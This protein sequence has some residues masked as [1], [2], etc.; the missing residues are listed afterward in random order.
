MPSPTALDLAL[1]QVDLC[2]VSVKKGLTV[3]EKSLVSS[4]EVGLADGSVSE[5]GR[6]EKPNKSLEVAKWEEGLV[7]LLLVLLTAIDDL[8]PICMVC[9][10]LRIFEVGYK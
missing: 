6:D 5:E 9:I 2:F 3:G 10:S 7:L 8:F 1:R 4:M